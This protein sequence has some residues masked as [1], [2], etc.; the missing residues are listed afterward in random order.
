M[1]PAGFILTGGGSKLTGLS[2][3][4]KQRLKL[5]VSLSYPL[6]ITSVTDKVNDLSFATAI[7]LVKWG[8]LAMQSGFGQGNAIFSKKQIFGRLKKI[9]KM[10]VP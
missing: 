4:A 2:E 6:N 5:P 7:G 1:L 10:F 3:F 9:L 8:S